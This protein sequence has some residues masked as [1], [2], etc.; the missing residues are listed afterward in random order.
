MVEKIPLCCD[1]LIM[2]RYQVMM[3]CDY[4]VIRPNPATI[5]GRIVGMTG[6]EPARPLGQEILSLP[7]LPIPPHSYVP[8]VGLEPTP[9]AGPVSKTGVSTN[10]TIKA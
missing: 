9:L 5:Y 7:C 1:F 4:Q 10:S 6:L 3:L 2:C 8:I